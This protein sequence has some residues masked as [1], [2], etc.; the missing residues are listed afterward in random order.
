MMPLLGASALCMQSVRPTPAT[1]KGC[2]L[3]TLVELEGSMQ[4]YAVKHGKCPCRCQGG[5]PQ[6]RGTMDAQPDRFKDFGKRVEV[7]RNPIT[8][9]WP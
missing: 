7:T 1:C 2:L 6:C 4:R 8:I 3:T 5:A 9:T